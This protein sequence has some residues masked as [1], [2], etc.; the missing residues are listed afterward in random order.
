[1]HH[2]CSLSVSILL[3][4]LLSV[5]GAS[6]NAEIFSSQ[7]D[8]GKTVVSVDPTF[9]V[10]EALAGEIAM[11]GKT[12]S[13]ESTAKHYVDRSHAGSPGCNQIIIALGDIHGTG[14]SGRL[15]TIR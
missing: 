8:A 4:T 2:L 3:N 9:F 15:N 10:P 6:E 1:M 5:S 14:F 12:L 13:D 7:I 11:E